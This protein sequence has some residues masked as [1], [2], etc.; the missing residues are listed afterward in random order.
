[1]TPPLEKLRR[2]EAVS[3][4]HY[5]QLVNALQELQREFQ[6]DGAAPRG[7][8]RRPHGPAWNITSAF[9]AAFMSPWRTAR[10]KPPS[11]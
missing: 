1:M 9:P 6:R 3:A 10:M 8:T 5:N 4:N 11:N 7:S 2:G